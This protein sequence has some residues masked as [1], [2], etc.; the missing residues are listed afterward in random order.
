[1]E[2]LRLP[3]QLLQTMTEIIRKVKVAAVQTDKP[4]LKSEFSGIIREDSE[5]NLAFRVAGP[6]QAIYVKEGSFVKKGD[7]IAEIDPRD[8]QVQV[9]VARAQY[10]QVKAE[11]GRV[12]EMFNRKSIADIDFEK[13]VSGEKMVNAQL[14]HAEH[15]LADTKL[16][17]PFS[18]YIQNINFE[19]GEMINAGM[20][21]ATL[22]SLNT[23]KIEVDIPVSLFVRK[24]DF[25]LFTCLNNET[26]TEEL[27]LSLTSFTV[28]ADNNQLY[29]LFL[30][31]DP[32]LG[33]KLAPGMNVKVMIYYKNQAEQSFSVPV[34]ALF[35][36][37]GNTYVWVFNPE[38]S[39][40]NKRRIEPT[41]LTGNGNIRITSGLTGNE[42]IVVAGVN[43]LKENQKVVLLETASKTN[44]GGLL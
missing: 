9:D 27:P 25:T 28:K 17:A 18:G 26:G 11:T 38:S 12:T 10:E 13:A 8:Y 6:I 2:N 20:T 36:E 23:Y 35:Y 14:K 16:F 4:V 43:V 31:L 42:K 1:M 32:Q 21:F 44:I 40:I 15:Q 34:E 22:I 5:N 33:K 7:L 24:N 30:N 29:K 3:Q 39:V 37:D 41:A 19:K